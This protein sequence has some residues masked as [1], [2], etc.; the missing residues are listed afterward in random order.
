MKNGF[1]KRSLKAVGRHF[2]GLTEDEINIIEG[3]SL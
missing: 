2:Y 3:V 1:L